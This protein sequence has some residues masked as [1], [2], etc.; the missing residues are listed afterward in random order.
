MSNV[1]I[2]DASKVD[3][4]LRHRIGRNGPELDMVHQFIDITAQKF[5]QKKTS[6]AV[7]IEPM[8]DTAYPDVVFA[9]YTPNLLDNWHPLRNRLE[10]I[11][12]KIFENIRAMRGGNASS[13]I[14]RTHFSYKTIMLAIE[15]LT[16]SGLIERKNGKWN[17]KPL[18]EIY[19]IKR[20][21]SVE[22]KMGQ[23]D[24]LLN[25]A[26]ANK[27]F[28]S[29]SYALSPIKTPKESTI[30]RF[31]AYG[32]GLYS[33]NDGEVIEINKAEKQNLPT[34]YMSWM[35]NEWVGRYATQY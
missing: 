11:D 21:I 5:K 29:E 33:F 1:I 26:D 32:I 7:F 31:K 17:S 27:W 15:R 13:I 25:Q 12:I 6:L 9:E 22:A 4:G 14:E 2:I 18:K 24:I 23:W 35:F 3:I 19:G 10:I 16:D 28:A 20:L 34:S 8:V 30:Q